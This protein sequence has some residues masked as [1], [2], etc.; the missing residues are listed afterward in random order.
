MKVDEMTNYASSRSRY[1]TLERNKNEPLLT[2]FSNK[3]ATPHSVISNVL[4]F[5]YENAPL[6]ITVR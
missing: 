3:R 4:I 6:R 1:C 5:R 2:Q